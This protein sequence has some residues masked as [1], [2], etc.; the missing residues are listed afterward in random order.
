MFIGFDCS[1][2]R[3]HCHYNFLKKIDKYGLTHCDNMI[4][5]VLYC[6]NKQG[7]ALLIGRLSYY[8]RKKMENNINLTEQ[9]VNSLRKMIN[10]SGLMPGET[11]ANEAEL[12]EKLN[13]SRSILREA[14]NRL[15]AIG[16][17]ESRQG[18]GLII[19]KSNPVALFEEA[20]SMGT[21]SSV[22]I[23]ELAEMRYALE[24]GVVD[25]VVRSITDEQLDELDKLASEIDFQKKVDAKNKIVDELELEFHKL[26]LETSRN[27]M[28]IRMHGIIAAFFHRASAELSHWEGDMNNN[29]VHLWSHHL[30]VETLRSRNVEQARVVLS[31]HLSGLINKKQKQE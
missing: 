9:A 4:I 28:I 27:T 14:V 10:D 7:F 22:E 31:G 12:A 26:Y 29:D 19:G 17:L 20:F 25:L 13:V 21:F 30:L 5:S 6:L 24:L 16:L 8:W 15:K 23:D 2:I 11:L 3:H 18:V 1:I